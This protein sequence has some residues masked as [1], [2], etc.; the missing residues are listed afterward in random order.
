MPQLRFL[1]LRTDGIHPSIE[2]L[3]DL[4][5]LHEVHVYCDS[6]PE[7]GLKLWFEELHGQMIKQGILD[8][9]KEL[10]IRY[11]E[12]SKNRYVDKIFGRRIVWERRL[13]DCPNFPSWRL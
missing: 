10:Y 12:Y 2:M 8:A 3:D 9:F 13:V 4:P 7:G 1:E 11:D 5:S 6:Y